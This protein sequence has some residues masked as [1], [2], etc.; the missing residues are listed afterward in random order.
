[1]GFVKPLS[2]CSAKPVVV[3]E[4]FSG[5]DAIIE[6]VLE[7]A[8]VMFFYTAGEKEVHAWMFPPARIS[9]NARTGYIRT[10]RRIHKGEIVNYSDFIECHNMNEARAKG[11]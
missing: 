7:K 11:C 2:L 6:K 3:V 10:S 1:V 8:G 9:S 4:E 5:T